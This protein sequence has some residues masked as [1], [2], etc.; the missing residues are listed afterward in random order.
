MT[1][2]VWFTDDLALLP[3]IESA[4]SFANA[5]LHVCIQMQDLPQTP[6]SIILWSPTSYNEAIDLQLT[7]RCN[8]VIQLIERDHHD[9][10]L[11]PIKLKRAPRYYI[12][13]PFEPEEAGMIIRGVAERAAK[14]RE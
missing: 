13:V 14:T 10:R 4:T 11:G 12:V 7:Q 6:V 5:T 9:L 1:T 2:V 8:Q 3:A